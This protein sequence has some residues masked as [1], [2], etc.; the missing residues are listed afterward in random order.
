T[1]ATRPPNRAIRPPPPFSS[2][3]QGANASAMT[4]RLY[5]MNCGWQTLPLGL[6]L[7]GEHARIRVPTPSYLVQHPRG[8]VLFDSGLHVDCQ[9]DPAARLGE[10]A[11]LFTFDYGP[12]DGGAAPPAPGGAGPDAPRSLVH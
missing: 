8:T 4:V 5:A 1:S 11:N 3:R 6:L 7:A 10:I 12:G 2:E 9:T